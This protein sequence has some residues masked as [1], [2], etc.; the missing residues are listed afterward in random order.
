MRHRVAIGDP[1]APF[2]KFLGILERHGLLGKTGRLRRDVFLVSMGDHFDYGTPAEREAAATGGLA[3]LGWLAGHPADQVVI[4]AGNHD[5]AR[6]GEL[7]GFSDAT[8][9][10]AQAE[11]DVVYAMTGPEGI[12]AEAA[13]LAKYPQVPTVESVARDFSNFRVAQRG[14]VHRLLASGRMR[15]AYAAA[16]DL[17]LTHAGVTLDAL[18]SPA[19]PAAPPMDAPAIA[20]SL[21]ERLATAYAAYVARDAAAGMAFEA[22]SLPHLPGNRARGEGDGIFYHRPR[23][24]NADGAVGSRRFDPRR[25]PKGITQVVGHVGDE[26]CRKLL[27]AAWT[28]DATPAYGVLRHLLT[29][30][31]EVRYAHGMP[32]GPVPK[33]SAAMLFVDGGMAHADPGAYELLDLDT[34]S[35]LVTR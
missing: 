20:A 13:F 7:A 24:P 33:E 6:V 34:R 12:A 22:P 3:L 15:A 11:A 32:A 10:A 1:Q 4:L 35:A 25:L 17:L 31:A 19:S 18:P 14:L 27:T 26:K 9:A 21:Q 8:F 30:G 16:P 2:E 28:D 5:L 29:D 23:K